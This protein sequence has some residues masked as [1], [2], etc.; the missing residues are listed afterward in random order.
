[1]AKPV[2][3]LCAANDNADPALLLNPAANDN[4]D[5][6]MMIGQ[7]HRADIA[8]GTRGLTASPGRRCCDRPQG[9]LDDSNPWGTG[10]RRVRLTE[11]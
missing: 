2:P 5:T 9:H 7:Q 10:L 3:A 4:A 11:C 1:M 6:T 8:A